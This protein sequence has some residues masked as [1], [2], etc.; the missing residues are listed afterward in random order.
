MVLRKLEEKDADG[1]LEWMKD[2]D[3]QKS[4]RF[5]T[6]NKTREDVLEFINSAETVPVDGKSIHYAIVDDNNEYL[7]TISLKDI[8]MTAKKAEYAI[9]L[10]KKAQGH[11]VATEATKEVL[12]KA[13]CEFGLERVY[14]NVLSDNIK[15]IHLYEKCGFV[16][17]GEF[18]KHL[19]LRGKYCDLKWYRMLKEEYIEM[20]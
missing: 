14:L 4:F 2:E 15:A 12:R 13:F 16:Y 10:R 6:A 8:D 17:E 9:S 1:M 7:G 5:D 18:K 19:F 11:G 3:I 20:S